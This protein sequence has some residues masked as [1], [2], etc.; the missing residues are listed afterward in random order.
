MTGILSLLYVMEGQ[1]SR[2][3]VGVLFERII[4]LLMYFAGVRGHNCG[5]SDGPRHQRGAEEK[6]DH[7][8][9]GRRAHENSFPGEQSSATCCKSRGTGAVACANAAAKAMS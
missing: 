6:G 9:D 2:Q 8:G 4:K 1:V 5:E 7:R 3:H